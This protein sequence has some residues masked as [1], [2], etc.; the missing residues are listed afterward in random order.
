MAKRFEGK[1]A[2]VTGAASGIGLAFARLIAAEGARVA[3]VDRD[4]EGLEKLAAV[5]EVRGTGLLVAA[6]LKTEA[7]PVVAGCLERGLLVNPV[8]PKTLRFAPPLIVSED[9]V[10]QALEI[11]EEVLALVAQPAPV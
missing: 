5:E 4:G 10:D 2:V 6:D 11:V 8:R 7:A 3:A 1:V 9:E